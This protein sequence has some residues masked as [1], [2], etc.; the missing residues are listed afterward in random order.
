MTLHCDRALHFRLKVIRTSMKRP[1]LLQPSCMRW[2][3]HQRLVVQPVPDDWKSLSTVSHWK[4]FVVA[5]RRRQTVTTTPSKKPMSRRHSSRRT[6][7]T[8]PSRLISKYLHVA[9]CTGHVRIWFRIFVS[10]SESS[11]ITLFSWCAECVYSVSAVEPKDLQGS[12][13]VVMLLWLCCD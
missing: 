3:F 8:A 9:S 5:V 6:A 11:E 12:K 4:V 13:R 7:K 10:K 1:Y 2:W